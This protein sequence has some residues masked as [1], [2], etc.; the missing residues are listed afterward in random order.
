MSE[1]DLTCPICHSYFVDVVESPCCGSGFCS[2][3][4]IESLNT[5]RGTCPTCRQPI[6]VNECRPNRLVQRMV[7]NLPMECPYSGCMSTTTRS[8]LSDHVQICQFRPNPDSTCV[9]HGEQLGFLCLEDNTKV[10]QYCVSVGLHRH[11]KWEPLNIHTT[12]KDFVCL[13]LGKGGAESHLTNAISST[14]KEWRS[15]SFICAYLEPN[16]YYDEYAKKLTLNPEDQY[17]IKVNSSN[18]LP[19]INGD[20]LFGPYIA[21]CLDNFK[22][23]VVV[24][25]S[26]CSL[27]PKTPWSHPQC[28]VLSYGRELIERILEER[29]KR[30]SDNDKKLHES[31]TPLI[32]NQNIGLLFTNVDTTND[33]EIKKLVRNVRCKEVELLNGIFPMMSMEK[34]TNCG[35]GAVL[36]SDGQ[37]CVNGNYILDSYYINQFEL[38][39]EI[40]QNLQPILVLENHP[41]SSSLETYDIIKDNQVFKA[42]SL[43]SIIGGHDCDAT[44]LRSILVASGVSVDPKLIQK[45]SKY[46]KEIQKYIDIQSTTIDDNDNAMDNNIPNNNPQQDMDYDELKDMYH[47]NFNFDGMIFRALPLCQYIVAGVRNNIS[48]LIDLRIGALGDIQSTRPPLSLAFALDRSGSMNGLPF[49]FAKQSIIQVINSLSAHDKF[50]LIVYDD[51]ASVIFRNGTINSSEELIKQTKQIQVGGCTNTEAGL[52][53]AYE[54]VKDDVSHLKRIFL[55]SDGHANAGISSPD[56]L[57]SIVRE[58]L[59]NDVSTSSFGIGAGFNEVL[60]KGIS[61]EGG[62]NYFFIDKAQSIP[63]LVDKAFKG[64]TRM[65]GHSAKLGIRGPKGI[66]IRKTTSAGS[67]KSDLLSG[68]LL[69]DLREKGLKQVLLD[70]EIDPCFKPVDNLMIFSYWLEYIQLDGAKHLNLPASPIHASLCLPCLSDLP[71]LPKAFEFNEETLVSVRMNEISAMDRKAIQLLDNYK[72]QE[73]LE[74]KQRVLTILESILPLDKMGLVRAIIIRT[75]ARIENIR[76]LLTSRSTSYAMVRKEIHCDCED[77]EDGDMGFGLFD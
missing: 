7:D 44:K 49:D 15:L 63:G 30:G 6:S 17:M 38:F 54:M 41:S 61:T 29:A 22:T 14:I 47:D 40:I 27:V 53:L 10:C 48:V 55:F 64:L 51:S 73:A 9:N 52:K 21:R 50:H 46:W 23:V 60:M 66:T 31:L 13:D 71:P 42:I 5:T 72:T 75:K 11:H 74:I 8:G 56:G 4:L 62:G 34:L 58:F 57:K 68:I 19:D 26:L 25:L 39:N 59:A 43:A 70:V 77:M 12:L 33:D 36:T 67:T 3:C 37:I 65:V 28:P 35:I 2:P 1:S 69:G 24:D 20:I 76:K 45:Y 18:S 32:R 16:P